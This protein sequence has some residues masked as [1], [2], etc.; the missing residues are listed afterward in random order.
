MDWTFPSSLV[1]GAENLPSTCS[2]VSRL[3]N[4]D[5]AL[6]NARKIMVHSPGFAPNTVV[7]DAVERVWREL[8]NYGRMTRQQI[9]MIFEEKKAVV[10]GA[11][12]CAGAGAGAP[13]PDSI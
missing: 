4:L 9:P 8:D 3:E 10:C 2:N 5:S 11:D 13:Q 12:D 6:G 1:T 7:A